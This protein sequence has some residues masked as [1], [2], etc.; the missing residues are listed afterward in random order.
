MGMLA[1]KIADFV[2]FAVAQAL[3]DTRKSPCVTWVVRKGSITLVN[4]AATITDA[5]F[6]A[7]TLVSLYMVTPGGTL[8]VIYKQSVAG[9]TVTVQSI[10]STGTNVTTDTSTLSYVAETPVFHGDQTPGTVSGDPENPAATYLTVSAANGTDLPSTITLANQIR[11]VL[12]Q[13]MADSVAHVNAD[14][15]NPVVAAV[16]V[17]LPSV[18]TLL[19]ACKTSFNAHLAQA[20]VH[21]FN[22]GANTVATANA[23]DLPT[24]EAL[25][26]AL[27]TAINAHMAAAPVGESVTIVAP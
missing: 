24:S 22:D 12:N 25:A 13:H 9:T 14:T 5:S 1:R 7:G 4:G 20:N 11:Q 10:S 19:N 3:S 21:V 26:N 15:T 16:A 27:K 8:G 17:D 6:N 23:S 2:A 18:E